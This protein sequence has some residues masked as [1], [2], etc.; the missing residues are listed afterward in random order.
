MVHWHRLRAGISSD[1]NGVRKGKGPYYVSR[2]VSLS[3][4]A[5]WPGECHGGRFIDDVL[6]KYQYKF[7]LCYA[8]DCLVYTKTDNIDDHLHDVG[9]VPEEL[10]K[11]SIK[12]NAQREIPFLG[13]V[14]RENDMI[15][16][17][18]KTKAIMDLELPK[19]R[20]GNC[21]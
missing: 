18:E 16:N 8:D 20:W 3:G 17:K 15:P 2:P 13:V 1:T 14:L 5:V 19:T 12:V 10:A 4:D 6:S 21:V 11:Y 7:V 9:L